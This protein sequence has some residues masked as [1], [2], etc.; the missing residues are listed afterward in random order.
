M[1][2]VHII[3]RER[4]V[5]WGRGRIFFLDDFADMPSPDGVRMALMYLVSDGFIVRLGE[6][7]TRKRIVPK[8]NTK[9]N[10]NAIIRNDMFR[11]IIRETQLKLKNLL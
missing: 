8:E 7:E 3:L 10:E 1:L 6:Q 5:E 9:V 4:I 11:D 2:P